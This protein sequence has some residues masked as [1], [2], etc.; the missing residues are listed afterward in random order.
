MVVARPVDFIQRSRR[1]DETFLD[2]V[3]GLGVVANEGVGK[4]N[5]AG[6]LDRAEALEYRAVFG[7]RFGR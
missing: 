4:A 3:V 1:L 5:R 7:D 2:E 6:V